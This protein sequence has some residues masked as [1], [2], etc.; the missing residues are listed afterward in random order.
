V[1]I[2]LKTNVK[3]LEVPL[4][5]VSGS[6]QSTDLGS[7]S[8]NRSAQIRR[9]PRIMNKL[10]KLFSNSEEKA[11]PS[12]SLENTELRAIGNGSTE[13]GKYDDLYDA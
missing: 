1:T 13:A 4:Y 2:T 10:S 6:A 5:V 9:T 11:L 8:L 3:E 12:K 7:Q